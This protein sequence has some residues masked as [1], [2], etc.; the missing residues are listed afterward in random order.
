MLTEEFMF[1]NLNRQLEADLTNQLTHEIADLTNEVH[2][3]DVT[4]GKQLYQD[5]FLAEWIMISNYSA[6]DFGD[7][8]IWPEL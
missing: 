6:G 8:F 5:E 3:F 2:W 4:Q 7:R 1:D